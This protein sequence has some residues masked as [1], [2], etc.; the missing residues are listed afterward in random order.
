[1]SVT[2]LGPKIQL[3]SCQKSY[4]Q[5]EPKYNIKYTYSIHTHHIYLCGSNLMSYPVRNLRWYLANKYILQEPD[6]SREVTRE[7]GDVQNQNGGRQDVMYDAFVD[8]HH[9]ITWNMSHQHVKS[10]WIQRKTCLL[11]E[12]FTT[13]ADQTTRTEH[14]LE[15]GWF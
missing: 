11:H 15:A 4:D 5:T 2:A 7:F 10:R 1:M 12:M 6:P 8:K 14:F 9:D 3:N 13:C